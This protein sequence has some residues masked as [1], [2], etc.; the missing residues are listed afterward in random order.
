MTIL[1]YSE[2]R[3]FD[4]LEER[5]DYL[6]LRGVVGE[7]TF[8]TERWLNQQFYTSRDWRAIRREVI[9]RDD[10]CDLG[11]P[12]FEIFDRP[13]IHHINPMTVG[14]IVN[15]DPSILDPEFLITVSLRT[16]NAIHYGDESQLP[17]PFVERTP[18]D[19]TLWRSI[20]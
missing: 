9:I 6:K 15:G 2:L 16:H 12:G 10:G 20:Q 5:Y 3:E 8:G 18:G 14:D 4:T 11:I 17:R 7:P 13:Y 19:T 1:T